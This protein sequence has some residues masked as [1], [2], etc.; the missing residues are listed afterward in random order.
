LD[1]YLS[2]LRKGSSYLSSL[3]DLY[4]IRS[5][6]F[7]DHDYYLKNNPDVAEN[8][9]DPA[10]HYLRYGGFEGRKPS[11]EFHSGWYLETNPDVRMAGLNPLVHYLRYGQKEHR[12]PKPV[13]FKLTSVYDYSKGENCIVFEDSP[14]QVYMHRPKVEGPFLG[15]L[16]E[17][18][19]FCPRPYVSLIKDAIIFG[20]ESLVVLDNRLVLDDEL[21][22]FN[23]REY[24]KKSTHIQPYEDGLLVTGYKEPSLQVE[25]GV[26]LSCG[27]DVNY[28]HWLVECLPKLLLVDSL[29]EFKNVPL[30]IQAGLHTNLMV[31]LERLNINNRKIIFVEPGSAC[32]VD[33]LIFPSALS[34]IVDRY[35]STPVFNVDIV[36]SY[37]WL[38]KVS[39]ILRSNTDHSKK[40]WRKIFLTR[41]KG[42]RAIRNR[43]EVELRLLEEG[44]EIVELEGASL[45]FQIELFS[46]ASVV[47]APTGAALTNMLFCRPGTRVIIFMSNHEVT[48]YYFWSSLGKITDLD[49]VIIASERLFNLTDYYSVHDDYIVDIQTVLNEIKKKEF[50]PV[51]P[52]TNS[53]MENE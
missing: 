49:V 37:K 50:T 35:E 33:R 20:G 40:T 13:V 5:S 17:G 52:M 41:R 15:T 21:V 10:L 12:K 42:L 36:L 7:F 48:N 31:A 51:I 16:N 39:E 29:E 28:F 4:L 46:Q 38:N 9:V 22:D 47:V 53:R 32:R 11:P 8:G 18:E 26:L 44:F 2:P 23:S 30:L 24:G 45:D 27:H 1:K 25:E 14:E 3:F 34:R 43:D 19:A 6:E